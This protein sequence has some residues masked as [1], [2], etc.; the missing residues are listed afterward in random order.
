MRYWL[1]KSEPETYSIESLLDCPKKTDPWEGVRNYQA[2]NFIRDDMQPEDLAFFYHSN[3]AI[4]GIVGIMKIVSTGY[5]DKTAWDKKSIY[6]D[7]KS[8]PEN[9]RWYRVDVQAVQKFK[10]MIPLTTLKAHP[11]L[12]NM[13]LVQKGNRL[14]VM[15]VTEKEWKTIL[16][17]I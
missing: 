14:S 15:P 3:C 8:T 16:T 10:T 17:L 11:L 4:P 9:P 1:M 12:K 2:R 13:A 7:P 5:P 6:F